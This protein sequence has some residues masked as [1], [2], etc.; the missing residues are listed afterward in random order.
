MHDA[1]QRRQFG[2]HSGQ[3]ASYVVRVGNIGRDGP[4]FAAALFAYRIDALLRGLAGCAPA[5]QHQMPGAVRGQISGDFQSDR[6]KSAGHEI[7]RVIT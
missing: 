5:G 1:G 2:P 3:D 6:T 7:C 4:D